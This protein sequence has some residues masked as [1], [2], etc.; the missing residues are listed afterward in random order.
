MRHWALFLR[1]N[2]IPVGA[3][4]DMPPSKSSR[5]RHRLARVLALPLFSLSM[6]L[7]VLAS[8]AISVVAYAPSWVQSLQETQLWSGP[9]SKAIS[10]G[11]VPKGRSF[12][13]VTTQNGPRLYVLDPG[14]NNYA[15][16]DA[17]A[18]VPSGPPGTASGRAA[19]SSASA[20]VPRVAPKLPAGYRAWWVANWV[21]TELWKGPDSEAPSLGTV[22]QFRKFMVVEP[23]HGNRLHV[24]SPETG[25]LGYLDAA[26][27]GPVGPSVRME[28][29]PITI[30]GH[31]HVQGRATGDAVYVRNLPAVADET[32]T[33][34]LPNNTPVVVVDAATTANGTRWYTLGDG[35]YVLASEI[36]L[37]TAPKSYLKGKWIDADLTE[38]AMLTAYDGDKIVYSA[39]AIIG[40]SAHPTLSGSY[41]ILRRVQ[42]ETMDSS[43]L[44]IPR[45]APGGYYLKDVL[46]TQYFTDQGAAIHY[47]YWKGTFGYPGSHGCLGL[48]LEDA[49]WFWDWA[50]VGTPVVVR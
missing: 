11:T 32:E 29:H 30:T 45:D 10:F 28:P 41:K 46:Y 39:L 49:R 48:N 47:N 20:S 7:A 18:V 15:Y 25:V 13:V 2:S 36:R 43:T 14:S 35:Q 37:P 1:E 42:N 34:H 22:P 6:I 19:P 3:L 40:E 4:E 50:S 17:A 21:E 33:R 24:W 16:I 12:L 8:S 26:A 9:D 44:G 31:L 38:P 27:V 23:Q 5:G